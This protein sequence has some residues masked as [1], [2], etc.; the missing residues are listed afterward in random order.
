MTHNHAARIAQLGNPDSWGPENHRDLT[1]RD[2]TATLA[3]GATMS[4]L[5]YLTA[6]KDGQLPLSPIAATVGLTVESVGSDDI[7]FRC[8]P[9]TAFL[10]PTGFIHGGLISTLMDSAL[11]CAVHTTLPAGT[12]FTTIELKVSFLRSVSA[13]DDLHIHGWVTKPG[14]RVAFAEATATGSDDKLIATASSSLLIMVG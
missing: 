3:L 8:T 12:G 6:M 14:Q 13:G 5:D 7:V 11:G 1:W 4:G 2:P 9:D 10:S